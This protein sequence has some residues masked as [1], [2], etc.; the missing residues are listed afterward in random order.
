MLIFEEYGTI[1]VNISILL[2]ADVKA[3]TIN[4]IIG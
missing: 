4:Q 3:G 2:C 1:N